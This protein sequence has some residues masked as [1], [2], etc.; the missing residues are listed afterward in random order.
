MNKELLNNEDDF[1]WYKHGKDNDFKIRINHIGEPTE[2]PCL[3]YSDFVGDDPYITN[4]KH[5][6]HYQEKIKCPECGHITYKWPEIFH[7]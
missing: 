5:V 4:M 7:D 6:F 3:V 2:Y 1:Y